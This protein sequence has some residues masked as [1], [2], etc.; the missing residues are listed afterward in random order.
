M[1]PLNFV[2]QIRKYVID[3]NLN[4][5]K[6]LYRNTKAKD[7]KDVF[8][9]KSLSLFNKLDND[10]KNHFFEIL[11]QVEIDTVSNVLGVIDGVVQFENQLDLTLYIENSN[12]PI[13]GELQDILLEQEELKK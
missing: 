2:N 7:V 3:E 13:N 6:D 10:E 1:K 8:W 4:I 5:Y 12:E 11:R 9:K